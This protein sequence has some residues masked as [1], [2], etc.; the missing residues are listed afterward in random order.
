MFVYTLMDEHTAKSY[1]FRL[2]TQLPVSYIDI[3]TNRLIIYTNRAYFQISFFVKLGHTFN[4][5]FKR[6]IW[7]SKYISIT[8]CYTTGVLH[9][10]TIGL[11][12]SDI[13]QH[14]FH[15]C[16]NTLHVNIPPEAQIKQ[17]TTKSDIQQ[18]LQLQ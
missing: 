9:S 13:R 12:F 2:D 18:K 8:H 3:L 17:P 10:L 16:I 7:H 4:G 6:G 15:R 14:K 11:H 5:V 1:R